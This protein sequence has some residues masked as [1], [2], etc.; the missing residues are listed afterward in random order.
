MIQ[1]IYLKL[2]SEATKLI[3]LFFPLR[4]R[5]VKVA[6]IPDREYRKPKKIPTADKNDSCPE[7]VEGYADRIKNFHTYSPFLFSSSIGVNLLHRRLKSS[8]SSSPIQE[9]SH[10]LCM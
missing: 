6:K 3:N 5:T 10:L 1:R 8:F 9:K 2:L 7:P 4:P